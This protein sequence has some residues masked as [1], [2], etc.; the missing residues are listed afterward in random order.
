MFKGLIPLNILSNL[1]EL[2]LL[3][4][5]KLM[6]DRETPYP[7]IVQGADHLLTS[8]PGLATYL[9]QNLNLG[10][11]SVLLHKKGAQHN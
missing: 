7:F 3:S 6:N 10:P 11:H 4:L 9:V 8:H 1:L 2:L 5:Q